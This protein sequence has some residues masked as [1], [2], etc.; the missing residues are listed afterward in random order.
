MSIP[1]IGAYPMPT[2]NDV[3]RSMVDWN[4]SQYRAVLLIHDMQN[5]F[6][7]KFPGDS[8]TLDL[9]RNIARLRE[10]CADLGIPVA[11]TAQPGGMNSK[12]R[13]L[14]K[15]FWGPG[16]T[17]DSADREIVAELAPADHERVFTKWRYSAF[18]N[19]GLLDYLR[20]CGRD[21]LIVCGVYAHVGCLIT[22]CDA[23]S[24]DIQPFLVCDAVADFSP[25]EHRMAVSYAA[26]RCAA[27]PTT[28]QVLAALTST[29]SVPTG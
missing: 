20:D 14:L 7:A 19:S 9:V 27:V 1:P 25:E 2:T 18:H 13:G 12:Q 17:V 24:H 10:C 5:Y 22:A 8:P 3:P 11:Y 21:Q 28:D 15:D 6:L 26:Q 29:A 4:V 16:M 23:F